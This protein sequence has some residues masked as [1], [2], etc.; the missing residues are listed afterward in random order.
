MSDRTHWAALPVALRDA[1][2]ARTGT[3]TG[4][5]QAPDGASTDV[6]LILHAERGD[7]FI[8]G[9][10][11]DA[12]RAERWRLALGADLAPHVPAL[13]PSP[14]WRVQAAGW[15]VTG[16][17]ALTGHPAD[18][19]PGSD[20]I[21]LVTGVLAEL[22]GIAAPDLAALPDAAG[23]WGEPAL[24]GA[25]LA[26]TD[27]HPGN[28]VIDSGRAWL[29]D[30]GWAIRGAAWLTAARIMPHLIGAG[31]KPA[32]AEEL[33]TAVP[34]WRDAP[35][36]AVTG[37][38]LAT[39]RAF[40]QAHWRDRGNDH[41]ADWE[42]ITRTWAGHRAALRGGDG[43]LDP[44]P[45]WN[46]PFEVVAER[47]AK[48]IRDGEFDDAGRLPPAN[49]IAA[50]YGVGRRAAAHAVAELDRHGIVRHRRGGGTY[51]LPPG[52]PVPEYAAPPLSQKRSPGRPLRARRSRRKPDALPQRMPRLL[53]YAGNR[54]IAS[55]PWKTR[56][57]PGT[58]PSW[59]RSCS[60]SKTSPK[61]GCRPSPRR[62]DS[63][64]TPSA[65]HC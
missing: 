53:R 40:R 41:R 63:T 34:A 25:M 27:P 20:D 50:H 29:I 12:S 39:A 4:A 10:G 46:W 18:L 14:L 59:T 33:L 35:A 38:A 28:F 44:F 5:P 54:A 30:W 2:E 26:H 6:R 56:G 52:S 24:G 48:R 57:H 55:R 42:H 32:D 64:R 11:P 13:S 3:V 31:W 49:V 61:H 8:K 23:D 62:Q 1:I 37:H 43:D 19:S 51:L 15:D 16:W 47:L 21:P 45:A 65:G 22:A 17:P 58:C 7:V 36:D 9:T 60:C